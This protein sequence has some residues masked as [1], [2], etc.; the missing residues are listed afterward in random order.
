MSAH[1]G[2]QSPDSAPAVGSGPVRSLRDADYRLLVESIEDYGIFML[3]AAGHVRSWNRGAEKLKGYRADEIIGEH[4]SRFYTPDAIERQSPDKELQESARL[5]RFEDEGWRVRKDGTRFWANVVITALRGEDGALAG[6]AKVTRDLSER[7]RMEELE[8]EGRHVTEFLAMLAHELRNPLAPIRNAVSI[9]AVS[10]DATPQVSWC[11]DVIDRQTTH[12]SRLVDDLLDVSRITRGKLQM[13]T[14]PMDLGVAVQR[15]IETSRPLIESRRHQLEVTTPGEPVCVQGDLTRIAQVVSNL[16]N[17]AAKY[18]PEGGRISVAVALDGRDAVLRVKDTGMGIPA[19]LIERV[20]DL[21]AQGERTLDRSAG[22]LGI[23]LT[24]ARRIVALHGGTITAASA[25]AGRG[26]EFTV[27]L[28]RMSE[29][30]RAGTGNGVSALSQ[31]GNRRSIVVVDDNPDSAMSMAMLLRMIGHQVETE[32]D[33]PSALER[34]AAMKPEIVFLDI[35]LP[36]MNGYEV[37]KELRSRPEGKGMLIYA[38]TGYGQE[39]DRKRSLAAGFDGH[40]VKPVSSEELLAVI[41]IPS[42][43]G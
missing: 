38:M 20:F 28:P 6:F 1:A 11:R 41:D 5:G 29:Q 18:T 19:S 16:L 15:A 33:G 21:F 39:E 36:G 7:K 23:G 32:N 25:G 14:A 30:D 12:L 8:E 42:P 10:Q 27:R 22:G 9:L 40:L 34:I 24:L 2:S 43:R 35:G 26:A 13:H 3:D 37:A 31:T 17:N 4:F